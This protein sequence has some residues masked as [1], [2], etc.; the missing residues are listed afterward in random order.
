M[1]VGKKHQ[2][3]FRVVVKEAR[4]PRQG[5]Y[6]ELV[7]FYNPKKDPEEVKLNEERINYWLSKGAK[8]T[9]TVERLIKKYTRILTDD[10]RASGTKPPDSSGSL[11][12]LKA[13]S[14]EANTSQQ[15]QNREKEVT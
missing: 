9:E 1:K 14:G 11:A 2:A 4:T 5:M 12:S 13:E 6:L 10:G 8:P 7:G 15:T 3:S